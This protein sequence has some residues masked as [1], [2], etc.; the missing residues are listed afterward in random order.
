MEN[1]HNLV[2]ASFCVLQALDGGRG[3]FTSFVNAVIILL[4]LMARLD[5]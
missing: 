2:E 3:R 1:Y 4:T 5:C